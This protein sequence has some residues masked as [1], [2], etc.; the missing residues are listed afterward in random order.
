M[1]LQKGDRVPDF[2]LKDTEGNDFD[3]K[4]LVGKQAFVLYFYPKDFT[5]GCTKEACEFRDRY[6]DFKA[7]GV[8]VIGVSSDS[9]K[10][11]QRFK[12]RYQ[13]PFVFLSDQKGRLRKQFGIKGDLFG[14]LPGR[15]TYVVDKEGVIQ[16]QFNSMNASRHITKALQ[17]VEKFAK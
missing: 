14:L 2:V 6:E 10:S 11:H 13:L 3:S 4:T 17:I 12:K 5:P 15:E 16:L 7:L 1:S 8:E 9:V